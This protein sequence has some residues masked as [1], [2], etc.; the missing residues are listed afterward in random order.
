MSKKLTGGGGI[1][2]ASLPSPAMVIMRIMSNDDD[3]AWE[4][5]IYDDDDGGGETYDDDLYKL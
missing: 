4:V 1:G 5:D 2:G 3:R